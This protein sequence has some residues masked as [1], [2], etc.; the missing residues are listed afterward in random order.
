M[1]GFVMVAYGELIDSPVVSMG[2]DPAVV[3]ASVLL[4]VTTGG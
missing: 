1:V 2:A 3:L 4:A